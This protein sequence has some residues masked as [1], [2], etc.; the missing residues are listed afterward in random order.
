M[1]GSFLSVLYQLST[2]FRFRIFS[3]LFFAFSRGFSDL[4]VTPT[5]GQLW[6]S[7]SSTTTSSSLISVIGLPSSKTSK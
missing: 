7:S 4:S 6:C 2:L 5:M 3:F 1:N